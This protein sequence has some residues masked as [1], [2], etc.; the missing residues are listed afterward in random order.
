MNQIKP[1]VDMWIAVVSDGKDV[2]IGISSPHKKGISVVSNFSDSKFFADIA[3]LCAVCMAERD[4]SINIVSASMRPLYPLESVLQNRSIS[5][6]DSISISIVNGT[7]GRIRDMNLNVSFTE[8][9]EATGSENYL[10]A[11]SL[12]KEALSPRYIQRYLLQKLFNL[13]KSGIVVYIVKP[14][15]PS[16]ISR[17]SATFN[18][19]LCDIEFPVDDADGP[20]G[21]TP[22]CDLESMLKV[23]DSMLVAQEPIVPSNVNIF[24][25]C[26]GCANIVMIN[27][28]SQ[29]SLVTEISFGG[30]TEDRMVMTNCVSCISLSM[31][32]SGSVSKHSEELSQKFKCL[33]ILSE[34]FRGTEIY[35]R[36]LSLSPNR[37]RS[38]LGEGE[39]HYA[40]IET[41][42]L[43]CDRYCTAYSV[44]KNKNGGP[45]KI[46]T[47]VRMGF[48]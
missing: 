48:L 11:V 7:V 20:N 5:H 9:F 41:V 47:F 46:E 8:R 16:C 29:H 12:A 31:P 19:P 35:N 40:G 37:S 10:N 17:H 6:L 21:I 18:L 3:I 39:V 43:K 27:C 1:G 44:T 38:I 13:P 23:K 34:C 2:G 14:S 32:H 28:P 42:R 26:L 36:M 45:D 22:H 33:R 4:S 30:F 25:L 24:L 15:R